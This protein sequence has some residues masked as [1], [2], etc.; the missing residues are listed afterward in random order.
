MN[1]IHYLCYRMKNIPKNIINQIYKY[2]KNQ[3]FEKCLTQLKYY[4]NNYDADVIYY[5]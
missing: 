2:I 5:S 1:S 3:D 4:K